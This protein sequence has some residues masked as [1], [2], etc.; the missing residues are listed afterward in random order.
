MGILITAGVTEKFVRRKNRPP[1]Q[2]FPEKVVRGDKIFWKKLSPLRNN[3][4]PS[5]QN[6]PEKIV[7]RTE[8]SGKICPRTE[9]SGKN[10][11]PK[12]EYSGKKM[13]DV[14]LTHLHVW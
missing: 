13:S 8:F 10:C 2:N 12:I 7:P 14:H 9:L 4:P 6:F 1:G 11:P 3:C 5:G